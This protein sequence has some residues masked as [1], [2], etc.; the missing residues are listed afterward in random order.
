MTTRFLMVLVAIVAGGIW[1]ATNVPQAIDLMTA[2]QEKSETYARSE[3]RS[4]DRA[5]ES[6]ARARAIRYAFEEWRRD[7]SSADELTEHYF[8]SRHEREI[9][10]GTYQRALATYCAILK[11]KYRWATWFPLASIP[12]DPAPPPDPLSGS[13]NN[14]EPDNI[15]DV[16]K[17]GGISVAFS[18]KGTGLAVGCRDN[19]IRLLELPS[20]R[21]LAS[22]LV[23][24]E[25]RVSGVF[26]PDGTTL[27]SAG[28]SPVVWR[29]DVATGH[30]G[31]AFPWTDQSQGQPG[32]L[33][34]A[35][36]VAC[37]PNGGTIAIAAAGLTG[38]PWKAIH[39]VRL[40]DTRTGELK[41]EHKRT[42]PWPNSVA[43]SPDG[44]TLACGNGEALLFDTRTGKLTKTLKPV[45]SVGITVAFSPD[46]RTLAGAGSDTGA[47][48]IGALGAS[49]R[50]TLWD[51]ATGKVVRALEGPTEKARAVAFS[52]DG[53]TVAA[54]GTG[55]A[56]NLRDLFSGRVLIKKAS[57]VRLWDVA[58]GRLSWTVEGESGAVFSL[59]FSPNGKSL[60]FC[61]E[62]YVYILDAN[63]GKLKQIVME[64]VTSYRVRDR[65]TAKST[66]VGEGR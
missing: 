50:V 22:F 10:D 4:R 44:A 28:S 16:I 37:S 6:I 62:D 51:V 64:T 25:I 27:F 29:W 57:E 26:S 55:P 30:A 56:T 20:R 59:S 42:G 8:A 49:G 24:E 36:A 60:A 13:A 40:L 47:V 66:G 19:T 53:R 34:E 2:Y 65:A 23:P 48:P 63:T 12:P 61:D 46:G 39:T 38:K 31:P 32:S 43:F 5:R 3:R 18:P 11:N 17:V 14:F 35:S 41:W 15:S 21:A 58:T 1:A 33:N 9:I 52:P 54:G 45:M 7:A